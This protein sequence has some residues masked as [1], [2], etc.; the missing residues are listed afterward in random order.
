MINKTVYFIVK[1]K[2]K[3]VF[4]KADIIDIFDKDNNLMGFKSYIHHENNTEPLKVSLY[5]DY[6]DCT[7]TI[8]HNCSDHEHFDFRL[9]VLDEKPSNKYDLNAYD[10]GFRYINELI[11]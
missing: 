6:Y 11:K 5:E 1:N 7:F 4:P 8:G 2:L 3:E 10:K 9:G